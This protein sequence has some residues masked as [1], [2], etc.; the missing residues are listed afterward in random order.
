MVPGAFQNS[1]HDSGRAARFDNNLIR[2]HA[3]KIGMYGERRVF[4]LRLHDEGALQ[5]AL[6]D[7][8]NDPGKIKLRRIIKHGRAQSGKKD[9]IA[10]RDFCDAG[11]APN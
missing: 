10:Q 8:R 5:L 2:L 3:F 9:T 7:V 1:A 11:L 4:C 6:C